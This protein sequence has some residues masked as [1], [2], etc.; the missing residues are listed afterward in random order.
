MLGPATV[1]SY[2][3]RESTSIPNSYVLS[4][5]VADGR[6]EHVSVK[7]EGTVAIMGSRTYASM[8]DLLRTHK[9]VPLAIPSLNTNVLLTAP[10]MAAA[11]EDG[12]EE[13]A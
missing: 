13:N 7:I 4:I 6:V 3:L 8:N 2:V 9:S 1:G 12:E 10:V 11:R 5:V